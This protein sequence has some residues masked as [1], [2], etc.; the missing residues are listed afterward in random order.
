VGALARIAA[1]LGGGTKE[2]A[3]ALQALFEA[4][5]LAFQIIDD[6]LNLR[7]FNDNRKAHAEDVT[8]GKVTAPVAKA[9]GRLSRD[10]RSELWAILSGK[11]QRRED[12]ARAVELIDG[13]GAL[14]ACE[15]QA[16][17]S[18]EAA[19]RALDPL[20]PDSQFKVRLRAFGWFVLDRH[21]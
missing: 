13:C 15:E 16:Q 2:Q 6:V 4:Y 14:D 21:Y 7:G 20:I 11:P 19:W 9:M 3:E 17:A 10:E 1:L 5:G 18:I 12:V 8:E